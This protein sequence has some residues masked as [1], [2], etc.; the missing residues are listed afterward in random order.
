LRLAFSKKRDFILLA[1]IVFVVALLCFST[2]TALAKRMALVVGNSNYRNTTV[3]VN[4]ANDAR[5]MDK[6]LRESGFEVTLVLDADQPKLKRAMLEFGRELRKGVDASLFYY[7]GHGV[8]VN[9]ENYLVPVD[10]ALENEDEVDL[11]AIAVN[12]FLQTMESASSPVNIV[13]LDACRNNPFSRAFRGS[14]G[15]LAPVNAPRGSFIAYA[16]APGAVAADGE[17]GNSPYTIALASVINSPGMKLE[18]VFKKTREKV[19]MST[20]EKQVP[21]ETSSITGDFFFKGSLAPNVSGTVVNPAA[22]EWTIVQHSTSIA[23]LEAFR[24][25][26]IGEPLYSILAKE[27]L[28]LLLP[29]KHTE[30]DCIGVSSSIRG[31]ESCLKTGDGFSDCDGCPTMVVVPAGKFVMGSP[32]EEKDRE[33]D[34]GPQSNQIIRSAFAVGKFEVTR[35]QFDEFVTDA[36]HAVGFSCWIWS[37]TEWIEFPGRSFRNTGFAQTDSHPASCI[38]WD[39]AQAYVKWLSKKSGVK[40]RLLREY[41]WEYVSRAGTT[42]A[43]HTGSVITT[44]QANFNSEKSGTTVAANFSSNS[45]GLFDLAGNVGEWTQDCYDPKYKAAGV[46]DTAHNKNGCK[47]VV[48]GGGWNS[49]PKDIRSA[50]RDRDAA[51][52]RESA[53]GFRLA[54]DF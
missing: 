25:K 22:E 48:R 20:N 32:P 12:A 8:Q 10:A 17:G 43:F 27:K 40:Y 47:R 9:G 45:F 14:G 18:D 28:A 4:P 46:V 29:E 23:V 49:L 24:D 26:Y 36:N 13:V 21:W 42:T 53:L 30:L 5:L 38:S 54:R 15:G 16:T 34:E 7:A 50:N 37:G 52:V 39:D 33:A 2:D 35:G 11:Q 44:A 51:G 3:L 19:L 41:E 1:K 6:V 31:Q